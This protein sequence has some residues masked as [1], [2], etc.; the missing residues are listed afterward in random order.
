LVGGALKPLWDWFQR[1]SIEEGPT[2]RG[3]IEST[4]VSE[5]MNRN[6]TYYGAE[7]AYSYSVSGNIYGGWMAF[8][9]GALA[10]LYSAASRSARKGAR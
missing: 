1:R 9:S 4:H 10:I 6:A 5:K 2:A 7:L 3:Q 8:Y